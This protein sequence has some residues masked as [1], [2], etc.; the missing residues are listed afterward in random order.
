ME[1]DTCFPASAAGE[2]AIWFLREQRQV[3][4][5]DGHGRGAAPGSEGI[6]QN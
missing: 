4:V 2:R 3:G 6:N 5:Q 1:G